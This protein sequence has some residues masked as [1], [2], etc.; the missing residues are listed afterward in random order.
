M[1]W[2][3]DTSA[4][5]HV[6]NPSV[7]K[8][9]LRLGTALPWRMKVIKRWQRTVQPSDVIPEILMFPFY[10]WEWNTFERVT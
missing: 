6:W 5:P 1:T 7:L 4:V 9:G 2:R 3:K 8:L 10:T